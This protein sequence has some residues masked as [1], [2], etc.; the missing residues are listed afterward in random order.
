MRIYAV[1]V[2][3]DWYAHIRMKLHRKIRILW[4]YVDIRMCVKKLNVKNQPGT[5]KDHE[6]R[7]ETINN[8]PGT[9]KNQTETMKNHENRSGIMKNQPRTIKNIKTHLEPWNT[10]LEPLCIIRKIITS[11]T[12]LCMTRINT[13]YVYICQGSD[14]FSLQTNRHFMSLMGESNRPFRCLDCEN[15]TQ[16][17]LDLLLLLPFVVFYQD[18]ILVFRSSNRLQQ[19]QQ[20]TWI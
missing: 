18:Y 6:N 1:A 19:W 17:F 3:A 16:L 14:D 2:Y 10:D 8:Q 13:I 11:L 5:M 9:M 20:W 4:G 12:G 7:P 15:L